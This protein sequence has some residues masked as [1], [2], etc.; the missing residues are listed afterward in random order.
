MKTGPGTGT[1]VLLGSTQQ[2]GP[3]SSNIS[4]PQ[5]IAD[6]TSGTSVGPVWQTAKADSGCF[7]VVIF[8]KVCDGV[9]PSRATF[10]TAPVFYTQNDVL[11]AL[12]CTYTL[13]LSLLRLVIVCWQAQQ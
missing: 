4:T 9:K 10:C 6:I 7:K 12:L 11:P 1:G 13:G 5:S 8:R 3:C 2:K